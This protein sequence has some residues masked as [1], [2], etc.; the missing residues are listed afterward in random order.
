MKYEWNPWIRENWSVPEEE[1]NDPALPMISIG[2]LNYNRCVELRQTLDVLTCAVQYPNYEIIV[3]DNGS[4]DGSIEMVRLEYPKV[5]L[6]E[7]GQNL[8]VSARNI[9]FEL[10]KGKYLFMFD[11][12]TCPGTPA[13]VLRIMQH[14]EKYQEIDALSTTYYQ[15]RTGINESQ[16]WESFRHGGDNIKGFETIF[17]AEGGVCFRTDK[18]RQI[19]GYDPAWMGGEGAELAL[20]MYSHNSGTYFCPWFLTLHFISPS[21][22]AQGRS[23]RGHRAYVN[24]RQGVWI[25][26]KHWPI[27]I[28]IPLLACLV[29]RRF[30]AMAM[31]PRT[32][33]ENVQGLFDGFSGMDPFL[34]HRPKLTWKQVY[35]LNRFYLALFRWA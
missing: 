14:M 19:G 35:G 1:W 9:E 28:A 20:Q 10:A 27:I 12:D 24:S 21:V 6:H 13:M 4:T 15:P 29:C 25:I 7:V 33:A 2:V 16:S 22:R 31:H 34:K 23:Y 3:I 18:L 32:L 5:L 17:L 26:S 11:D 30:L 8:G